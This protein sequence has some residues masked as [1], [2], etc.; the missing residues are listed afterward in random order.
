CRLGRPLYIA[1]LP[2]VFGPR[3]APDDPLRKFCHLKS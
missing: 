2:V 3:L 1:L